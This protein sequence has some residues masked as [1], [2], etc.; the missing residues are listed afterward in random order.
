[1]V[2]YAAHHAPIYVAA[3]IIYINCATPMPSDCVW[4]VP[5]YQE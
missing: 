3:G 5:G 4:M 2:Y 1:M